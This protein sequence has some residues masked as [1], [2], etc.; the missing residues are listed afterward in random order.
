MAISDAGAGS[1][2]GTVA[3]TTAATAVAAAGG[4]AA[5]AAAVGGAIGLSIPIPGLNVAI[6]AVAAAISA[7]AA[8]LSADQRESFNTDRGL[9]LTLLL[10]GDASAGLFFTGLDNSRTPGQAAF[11]AR[12]LAVRAG[13]ATDPATGKFPQGD[14]AVN[15]Y[16][17]GPHGKPGSTDN[18][19]PGD[20]RLP[21]TNPDV[22]APIFARFKAYGGEGDDWS[23]VV[24]DSLV[25]SPAEAQTILAWFRQNPTDFQKAAETLHAGN[26]KPL[27][28]SLRALRDLA[29]EDGGKDDPVLSPIVGDLRFTPKPRPATPQAP[30]A[31]APRAGASTAH[32]RPPPPAATA[33]GA[34]SAITPGR[35]VA[36]VALGAVALGAV[37]YLATPSRKAPRT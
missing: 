28:S 12:V 29:G 30:P 3:T 36:A 37:V 33:S 17:Y 5:V 1:I 31:P 2:A 11:L 27:R 23:E 18:L 16:L 35:V 14:A 20:P 10:L 22:L 19:G 4:S 8:W 25:K 21:L 32:G 24:K 26:S 15:R 9:S 7:M 6:A 13:V 34:T